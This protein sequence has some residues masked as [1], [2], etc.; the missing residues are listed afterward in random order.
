MSNEHDCEKSN[1]VD[2]TY[3]KALFLLCNK[4]EKKCFLDCLH[5]KREMFDIFYAF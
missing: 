3:D 5:K 2:S 1:C 4:C